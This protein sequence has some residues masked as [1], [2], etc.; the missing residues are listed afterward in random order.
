[1]THVTTRQYDAELRKLQ[2]DIQNSLNVIG[3][4]AECLGMLR[5]SDPEFA[6]LREGILREH[7]TVTALVARVFEVTHRGHA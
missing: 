4:A 6:T 2:H 3:M 1:M 5:E 7:K